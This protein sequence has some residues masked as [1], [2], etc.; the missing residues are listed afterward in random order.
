MGPA[1][2]TLK[3]LESSPKVSDEVELGAPL[4]LSKTSASDSS[5]TS[6]L[7]PL[8]EDTPPLVSEKV[9]QIQD[10]IT[11]QE[12]KLEPESEPEPEPEPE[13]K[14]EP[15]K[16]QIRPSKKDTGKTAIKNTTQSAKLVH[17]IT[18]LSLSNPNPFEK[19]MKTRDPKLFLYDDSGKYRAYSRICPS[20]V[21]RQPV[22]LT[23]EEKTNIDE[24]HPG[25]YEHAIEYGSDP[26]K[27]FWYICPR[28][29]SLKDNTSLTEEEVKSGKY[30][31]VIPPK[32][33]TVPS[34]ASI[35]EF[36]DNG[37]EYMKNG[38]YIQHYPG[39]LKSNSHPEG[40][41]L[42]CCFKSWDS[43]EQKLRRE[44]CTQKEEGLP[45]TK[46]VKDTVD[47][48]IKGADKFPIQQ[49]RLG[50][51]PIVIQLFLKTDNQKCQISNTNVS[52]KP[53]YMCLLRQGVEI[54]RLQSFIA[55]I[56]DVFIEVIG[57]TLTIKEM[58]EQIIN[59]LDLD[60]FLTYQNGSL[61]TTFLKD[62]EIS[63]TP[64][65]NTF[66][67]KNTDQKNPNQLKFLTNAIKAYENFIAFLQSDS[68]VIDYTYLWDIVSSKNPKLFPK[69]LNLVILE[70]TQDDITD[71]V[72]L[73]CPTN[74]YSEEFYSPNKKTLILIKNDDYYEPIYIFEDV[75]DERIVTRLFSI[76]NKKL[77]PN[78][79]EVL[80]T[81][82]NL[83]NNNCGTF[84]SLPKV[85]KFKENIVLGKLLHLLPKA[86]YTLLKQV[87]NYNGKVIGV[88]IKKGNQ[89]GYIPCYP[90]SLIIDLEGG[91]IWI[92]EVIWKPYIETRDF[93]IKVNQETNKEVLCAPRFKVIEDLLIVGIITETNQFIG[94]NPPDLDQYGNDLLVMNDNNYIIADTTSLVSDTRDEE[95]IRLIKNIKLETSFYNAFRNTIR[96]LL[97]RPEY[98]E[99]REEIQSIINQKYEIYQLKLKKVQKLLQDLTN[100]SIDF[101]IN[102]KELIDKLDEITTCLV[103]PNTTCNDEK[104]CL[105]SDG[106]TC[107]LQ[108]PKTNLINGSDNYIKYFGKM[109]DELIRYNR[110]RHFIFEPQ[111]FL[112]FSDIKYNLNENEIIVIQS[113]LNHN[114][115][116]NIMISTDN[117]FVD[118]TVYD[119]VNPLK[120]IDYAPI[121]SYDHPSISRPSE[122]EDD[123]PIS[124][125][126]KSPVITSQSSRPTKKRLTLK[127]TLSVLP[128]SKVSPEKLTEED[129]AEALAALE[130]LENKP[131]EVVESQSKVSPEKLTE[132]DEAEALAA[133]EELENKPAEVVESQSR[134]SPEKL[135]DEDEA[136][137]LA[138]LEELEKD[139][140]A[141]VAEVA[142][143]AESALPTSILTETAPLET[144]FNACKKI[145]QKTLIEKWKHFFPSSTTAINYKDELAYCTFEILFDIIKDYI[146]DTRILRINQL[147]DILIEEY[148][149]YSKEI[150][151]IGQIL[152]SE[153]K[154]ELADKL[155]RGEIKLDVAI[156]SDNYYITNLDL[157]II[158]KHFNIPI[159]LLSPKTL[160][161]NN[162]P[163][164][165]INKSSTN[166]YYFILTALPKANISSPHK[167]FYDRS[168]KINLS[169]INL[170]LQTDIKTA[171]E[172]NL[173]EY[174]NNFEFNPKRKFASKKPNLIIVEKP[175]IK[176]PV[177]N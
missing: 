148:N 172:F 134:V 19:R 145:M 154:T 146:P 2:G 55:C 44:Q 168:N 32:A 86:G 1:F 121:L 176:K 124:I 116:N 175:L 79:K 142:E 133:L 100:N 83:L 88:L 152:H 122:V 171:N 150:Y 130:E 7:P 101:I 90:S 10:L 72:K 93:L 76:T 140:P 89:E 177:P 40:N 117:N 13:S 110:I 31:N 160:Q 139:K 5:I 37:K 6:E 94:I 69:G 174:I 163:F 128:P 65:Q 114:F 119:T 151:K 3:S 26:N 157:I 49:K 53:N 45:I 74:H 66:I 24:N 71:N 60:K 28:Y 155:L 111:A 11:P 18:G 126:E 25:S 113:L 97:G 106:N 127:P 169:K 109:A 21:R 33:K 27:K 78:L 77:L 112:S 107:K 131:A 162:K 46:S 158:A 95:R 81:I 9:V 159:I 16:F 147:K 30:G 4:N 98:R 70:M 73:I 58:K 96:I 129:E 43:K 8:E 135:T 14:P 42:P 87:L 118:T 164:M 12:S 161:E 136:E 35:F 173:T 103:K 48:Y 125:E 153:G 47:D 29:W 105:L 108:I 170:P 52:L 61:I 99:F 75:K 38:K 59:S 20:N 15:I 149:K 34:D 22:I 17:D 67:Y 166:E 57:K 143:V 80:L 104:Y 68:D 36:N 23:D 132:E 41:C 144:S 115:F 51:L 138:A 167:L 123:L 39:F 102:N 54:N 137:A 156:M 62:R 141:E 85:Y 91:M 63:L 56:A 64:Y 92:D 165:V 50:F 120:T 84:P 82:K